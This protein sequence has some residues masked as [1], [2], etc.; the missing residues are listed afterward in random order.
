MPKLTFLLALFTLAACAPKVVVDEDFAA[1]LLKSYH[2]DADPA[3][4]E[5][6]AQKFCSLD[7]EGTQN[8]RQILTSNIQ[9]EA[10]ERFSSKLLSGAASNLRYASRLLNLMAQHDRTLDYDY[11]I[12][13]EFIGISSVTT[14]TYY[15]VK[16]SKGEVF[17]LSAGVSSIIPPGHESYR[18]LKR[19]WIKESPD[20][21]G[22]GRHL[23]KL[24]Y[25]GSAA[26]CY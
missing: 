25:P 24:D 9:A 14:V 10:Q 17:E 20:T 8:L 23:V 26:V 21:H 13:G 22:S 2:L 11:I 15:K 16:T 7:P 18:G 12:E 3:E 6:M 4:I 5:Y 1:R 19:M